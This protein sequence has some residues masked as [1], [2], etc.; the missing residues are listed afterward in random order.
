MPQE[1]T[2]EMTEH[3][4]RIASYCK[5]YWDSRRN[6]AGLVDAH[7]ERCV[8]LIGAGLASPRN[9]LPKAK[10]LNILL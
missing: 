10:N 1:A 9:R 4:L 8:H 7:S 5:R 3:G 2:H 6:I